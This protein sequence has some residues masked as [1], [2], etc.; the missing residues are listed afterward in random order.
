ME[1]LPYHVINVSYETIRRWHA[2][3]D[4]GEALGDLVPR[5]RYVVLLWG[6]VGSTVKPTDGAFVTNFF[7]VIIFDPSEPRRRAET[8]LVR[9]I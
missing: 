7:V 2:A 6:S 4:A 3:D 9:I 1:L 8:M 5:Q